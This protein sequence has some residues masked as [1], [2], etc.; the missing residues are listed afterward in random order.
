MGENAFV[1]FT[2]V[3][4]MGLSWQA[5]LGAIFLAGVI[6]TVMT[7]ARVRAWMANAIPPSLKASFAVGIGLFLTFIGLY[8]TNI[9]TLGV[10]GAPVALGVL[11]SRETLLA[12][13]GLLLLFWLLIK[14]VRGAILIGIVSITTVSILI[15]ATQPPRVLFSLPP[16]PLPLFG[17]LDIPGALT[18]KAL[19]LSASSSFWRLWTPSAR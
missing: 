2:V 11:S 7:L 3:K 6:F 18:L 14:R 10:K 4:G 5:A 16:S 12:V 15:G 9:V 8:Q 1:A 13:G 19:P 17:Q